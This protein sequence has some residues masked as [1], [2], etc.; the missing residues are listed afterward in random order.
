MIWQLHH[1]F[2][3]GHTEFMAQA[4][5]KVLTNTELVRKWIKETYEKYPLPVHAT[6]LMCNEKSEYFIKQ[7]EEDTNLSWDNVFN[8]YVKC[9]YDYGFAAF[10]A[11]C[12]AGPNKIRG[13]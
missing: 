12:E 2:K 5:N 1:Q 8:K 7:I 10:K 4:S 6:W 11:D 13:G 3:N 9:G